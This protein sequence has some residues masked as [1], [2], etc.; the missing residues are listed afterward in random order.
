LVIHLKPFS[1][2]FACNP[3]PQA[4]QKRHPFL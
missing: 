3:K 4:L 1:R 2:R